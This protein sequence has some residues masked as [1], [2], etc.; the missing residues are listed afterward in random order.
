[1]QHRYGECRVAVQARMFGDQPPRVQGVT[2]VAS[3]TGKEHLAIT[4]GR[5]LLY[6]E[7]RV[8]LNALVD[9]FRQAQAVSDARSAGSH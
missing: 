2:A 4:I 3:R 1:M 9:A 7:D 8:A 5:V 6:V